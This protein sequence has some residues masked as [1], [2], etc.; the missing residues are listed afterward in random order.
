MQAGGS[1]HTLTG[2]VFYHKT[3]TC[4][5]ALLA[6]DTTLL[7]TMACLNSHEAKNTGFK[8]KNELSVGV[9]QWQSTSV[10]KFLVPPPA[11]Q[12]KKKYKNK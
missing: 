3:M 4:S 2:L 12:V 10:W 11:P 9:A 6:L 8:K 1:Y 5:M 7:I